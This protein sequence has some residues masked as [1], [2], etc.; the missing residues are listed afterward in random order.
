MDQ[1]NVQFRIHRPYTDV[2]GLVVSLLEECNMGFVFE[3]PADEE[4]NRTHIHGYMFGAK[5]KTKTISQDWI[6]KKLGLKGNTDFGVSDKCSRNDPRPIDMS[7]AYC[8]GSKW[9]TIAASYLKNISPDLLDELRS[10]ARSKRGFIAFASKSAPTTETIILK[11]IKV[12]TKPTLYQHANAC[13]L[14]ILEA[15]PDIIKADIGSMRK[16]VFEMTFNYI[17]TNELFMGKYKQLD[18]MDNVL[19]RLNCDEYKNLLYH[20]FLKRTSMDRI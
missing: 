19:T 2:S 14:Q 10:Y 20:D 16:C 1:T 5:L 18:F 12:K 17:R 15:R 4:V 3:H 8:Y 11:E 13:S 6:K 7:G 9:D